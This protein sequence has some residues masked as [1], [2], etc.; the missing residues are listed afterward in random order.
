MKTG[1]PA[2]R[3]R[4]RRG[5][6]FVPAV[7]L[8]G[9]VEAVFAGAVMAQEGAV[10]GVHDPSVIK[11]EGSL[12]PVLDGGRH[13]DPPLAGPSSLGAGGARLRGESRLVPGGRAGVGLDLGPGYQPAPRAS[14]GSTIRSRPSAPTVRASAWRRT[15]AWTPRVPITGGWTVDP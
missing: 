6:A 1:T 7:I 5:G 12:L 14:T 15:R 3:N 10:R 9:V 11:A 4:F 8:T 13:P 2:I